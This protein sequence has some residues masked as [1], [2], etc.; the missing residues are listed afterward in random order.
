M[1]SA[2]LRK[3]WRQLRTLRWAGIALGAAMPAIATAGAEA[4]ARGWIPF[5]GPGSWT[6]REVFGELTPAVLFLVVWPLLSLVFVSQAFTGD[7]GAGTE[8]FLLERPVSRR[9]VWLA[10][11]SAAVAS[12]GALAA[13][14]GAIVL[15]V[16]AATLGIEAIDARPMGVL[17]GAGLLITTVVAAAGLAASSLLRS[18]VGVVLLGLILAVVPAAWS[19]LLA[20]IFPFAALAFDRRPVGLYI[21]WLLLPGFVAAS[22]AAATRGEPAGRGSRGRAVRI[23]GAFALAVVVVFTCV[24]A[25]VVR[26]NPAGWTAYTVSPDRSRAAFAEF[27]GPLRLVDPASGEVIRWMPPPVWAWAWSEEGGTLAVATSAGMLGSERGVWRVETLGPDGSRVHPPMP[28]ETGTYP[29]S[30]GWHSGRVI[31]LVA[32]TF[33]D[34]G[35][36][37]RLLHANPSDSSWGEV[38]L[39]EGTRTARLVDGAKGE[40]HVVRFPRE[41]DPEF[42]LLE[43]RGSELD[44][45]E[46]RTVPEL[47]F[48]LERAVSPDGRRIVYHVRTPVE[49]PE[50]AEGAA[51]SGVFTVRP[52]LLD[53]E[54]GATRFFEGRAKRVV[55]L[56]NDRIAWVVRG[57]REEAIF[58]GPV[59]GGAAL[60]RAWAGASVHIEASPDGR[61]LLAVVRPRDDDDPMPAYAADRFEPPPWQEGAAPK[62]EAPEVWIAALD[63]GAWT[64]LPWSPVK[65]PRENGWW[66]IGWVGN[67]RLVRLAPGSVAFVSLD[68]PGESVWA[69]GGP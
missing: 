42:L 27:L 29:V 60:L 62:V 44:V 43:S 40:V 45:V 53:L 25:A 12:T 61:R 67:D 11:L 56:A 1:F 20:S 24:A 55:W 54:S 28:G 33:E 23:L 17:A 68:R 4:G 49:N 5:G 50:A 32:A 10:R 9:R 39:P 46:T 63:S 21:P 65:D 57:E 35:S 6:E 13:L 31:V 14:T 69:H 19:I 58:V 22:W 36:G 66:Q 34:S 15:A 18:Q 30:I 59:E 3:E 52:V 41:G 38:P 48:T 51:A 26:S 37:W 64:R 47:G 2:L 16:G 7:A 8:S